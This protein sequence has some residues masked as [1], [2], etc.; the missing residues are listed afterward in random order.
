MVTS[1]Q[2]S[3]NEIYS[4]IEPKSFLLQKMHIFYLTN[5]HVEKLFQV[6]IPVLM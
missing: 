1:V 5:M 2:S 4:S 6:V 3:V